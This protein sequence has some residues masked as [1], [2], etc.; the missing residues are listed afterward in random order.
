[1][2][3]SFIKNVPE[4]EKFES[5]LLENS[6]PLLHLLIGQ[7]IQS[8]KKVLES[9]LK[10][11]FESRELFLRGGGSFVVDTDAII[12]EI[13][14]SFHFNSLIFHEVLSNELLVSD[15]LTKVGITVIEDINYFLNDLKTQKIQKVELIKLSPSY[16]LHRGKPNNVGLLFEFENGEHLIFGH[17][18]DKE[19]SSVGIFRLEDI[20]ETLR[21]NLLF[22]C[23]E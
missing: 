13:A 21:P 8:I 11:E 1:M 22:E 12:F 16:F 3:M 7:K 2:T 10:E 9:K 6:L 14:A 17:H 5:C 20:R 23:I 19:I 4:K 15:S 18:L